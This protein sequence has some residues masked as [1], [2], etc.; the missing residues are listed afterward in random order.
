MLLDSIKE[1]YEALVIVKFLALMYSYL[2][3]S[4]SKNI[5]LDGIKGR[6]IHHSFPMTPFQP[7]TI[8]LDH[9]TLKLL[10]Y[11]TW[12]FVIICPVC[13]ILMIML[14]IGV[15]KIFYSL[16]FLHFIIVMKL[17]RCIVVSTKLTCKVVKLWCLLI[18]LT[19]EMLR[20]VML[21][22]VDG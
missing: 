15:T 12:K 21:E 18:H 3:I 4:I 2:N 11:W 20:I 7:H 19:A 6:E 8:R 14:Q 10:K 9:C 17:L 16:S 13:S 1:C 22:V 5:V